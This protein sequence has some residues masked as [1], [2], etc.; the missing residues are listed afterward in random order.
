MAGRDIRRFK[1]LLAV[2]GLGDVALTR[3]IGL[4]VVGVLP[5]L[6]CWLLIVTPAI[7]GGLV[8]LVP[9]ATGPGV[10]AVR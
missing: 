7:I 8:A 10:P 6:G 5:V 9:M 4:I 2:S 1:A 3:S